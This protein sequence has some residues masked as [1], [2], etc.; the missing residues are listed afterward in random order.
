MLRNKIGQIVN[1]KKWY[2]FL[3]FFFFL[4][5]LILPAERRR[6]WRK[7]TKKTNWTDF[8]LK[9]GQ[10]WDR[11]WTLQHISIHIYICCEVNI[12]SKFGLFKSYYLVQVRVIIWSKLIVGLFL[13]WFQ[14]LFANSVIT[15]CMAA[16]ASRKERKRDININNF[17]RWLPGLGGGLPTGWPGVSGWED[18]WPGWP[19]TCL[20]AKCL[21]AF[22]GP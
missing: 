17:F 12:R 10:F 20:C 3:V 13:L 18:R 9:K 11:F 22:S 6:F 2:F 15:L 21:C 8:Q 16:D 1:A 4:K 19:R 14:A 5:N 7:N